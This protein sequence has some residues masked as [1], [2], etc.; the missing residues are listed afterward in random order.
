MG[1]KRIVSAFAFLA[2]PAPRVGRRSPERFERLAGAT[3][4]LGL[5]WGLLLIGLW[6]VAFLLSWPHYL[7]WIAPALVCAAAMVAGPHRLAATAMMETA[8]G[9]SR[10]Q[11]RIV[12]AVFTLGISLVGELV[13][14]LWRPAWANRLAAKW[15]AVRQWKQW[16]GLAVL[17]VGIAVILNHAVRWRNPDWPTHLPRAWA[18]L[19]PRAVYRVLLLMP[20]WGSWSM[21]A[22]GQFHRPS[23]TTDGPARHFAAGVSPLA[24]AAWLLAPLAG[25]LIYLNFLYPWHFLP[26]AAAMLA[27]LGGGTMLVRLRGALSRKALLGTNFLTQLFFLTAYLS[28]R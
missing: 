17:G 8:I 4:L 20:V 13:G 11:G 3:M 26:P 23:A 6:H 24:A 28:V 14:S 16:L 22:L 21:L 19:W 1:T 18:W 2:A 25:S 10:W 27:A 9:E 5:A 7:N 15:P 12:G